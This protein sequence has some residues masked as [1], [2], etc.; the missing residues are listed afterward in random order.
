MILTLGFASHIQNELRAHSQR[1]PVHD[2]ATSA[3]TF[4]CS[5]DENS[6]QI[7]F[8]THTHTHTHTHIYI[9]Y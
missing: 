4:H 5:K 3:R 8:D 9:N 1:H 2:Q 6:Y 7:C